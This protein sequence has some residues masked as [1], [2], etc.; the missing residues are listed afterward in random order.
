ML[1]VAPWVALGSALKK[2]VDVRLAVTMALPGDTHLAPGAGVISRS[3][4]SI[5]KVV[6]LG[7]RVRR[8]SGGPWL[9]KSRLLATGGA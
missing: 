5:G 2:D 9:E 6:G 4:I 3:K 7:P 8:V 1:I